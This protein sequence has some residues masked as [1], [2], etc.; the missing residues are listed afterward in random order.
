M[1]GDTSTDGAFQHK[2][3][4][5]ETYY[6]CFCFFKAGSANNAP[7]SGGRASPAT[8]PRAPEASN[9]QVHQPA[10]P[11]PS[12]SSLLPT[13]RRR[14]SGPLCHRQCLAQT[15]AYGF[16][17]IDRHA[18]RFAQ[19]DPRRRRHKFGSN[20][21][22]P[23]G[24]SRQAQGPSRALDTHADSTNKLRPALSYAENIRAMAGQMYGRPDTLPS[25][26]V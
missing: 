11:Q 24:S 4:P 26:H 16:T 19:G 12:S 21:Q 6:V 14:A 20:T 13:P 23:S 25:R 2:S 3:P 7:T 1:F 9:I 10:L 17:H 15:H 5:N 18:N 22:T 8:L